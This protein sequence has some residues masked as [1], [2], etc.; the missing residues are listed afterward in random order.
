M[1]IDSPE[2]SFEAKLAEARSI[3][4]KEASER[5]VVSPR[6][7]ETYQDLRKKEVFQVDLPKFK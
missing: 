3:D 4:K 1:P 2:K 7:P 5:E 6:P